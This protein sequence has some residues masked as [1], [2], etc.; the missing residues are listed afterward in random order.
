[1]GCQTAGMHRQL[2]IFVVLTRT[3]SFSAAGYVL[4]VPR[5]AVKQA[6]QRLE[7]RL[8][9]SLMN[10]DHSRK[11]HMTDAGSWLSERSYRCVYEYHSVL[12]EVEAARDTPGHATRC[13][14]MIWPAHERPAHTIQ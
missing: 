9:E 8:G 4:G 11:I 1:M 10:V 2:E 12:A 3:G 13:L 7:R 6:I 14:D 5:Q